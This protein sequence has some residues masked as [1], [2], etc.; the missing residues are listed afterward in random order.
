MHFCEASRTTCPSSVPPH[1]RS[2]RSPP[3][4]PSSDGSF[5]V[6]TFETIVAPSN[7]WTE[8][9]ENVPV[10]QSRGTSNQPSGIAVS[11]NPLWRYSLPPAP[12]QRTDTALG[13]PRLEVTCEVY[14][15][16]C[17]S[18]PVLSIIAKRLMTPRV[19][20]V[21]GGVEVVWGRRVFCG[22]PRVSGM[23]RPV[24]TCLETGVGRAETACQNLLAGNGL[25]IFSRGRCWA[26]SKIFTQ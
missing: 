25:P 20:Q 7:H 21:C 11:S 4:A 8:V 23:K 10:G 2:A 15:N 16:G 26:T 13:L 22:P 24:G 6:E 5:V 19:C 3:T 14:K 1:T 12:G 9:R 18:V 17:I